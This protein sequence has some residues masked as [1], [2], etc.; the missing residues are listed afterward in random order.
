MDTLQ[1][2]MEAN[3]HLTS[4]SVVEMHLN[5]VSK[6]WVL[7]SEEDKDYIQCASDAIENGT[8]WNV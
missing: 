4:R 3:Q 8:K 1:D 6:F 7:L 2:M 5:S